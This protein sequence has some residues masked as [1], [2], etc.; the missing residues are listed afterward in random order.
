[1]NYSLITIHCNTLIE[2]NK[3]ARISEVKTTLLYTFD[4]K[5]MF[6]FIHFFFKRNWYIPRL[7]N[8][9]HGQI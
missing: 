9:E 5:C 1:M 4:I 8:E 6:K 2:F 3:F 7:D